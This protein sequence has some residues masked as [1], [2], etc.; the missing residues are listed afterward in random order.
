V[1]L[2]IQARTGFAHE[3][4]H[5]S[6]GAARVAD[7]PI[8]RCAVL[9]AEACNIGLE[10]VVRSAI[11]ALTRSR[12]SWVQ[13]NDLRADTLVRANACLVDP[14]TTIPWAQEWGGGAGASAEGLRVVVPVRTS[15]AGP[16]RQ[17]GNAE[18]GVPY[19][20]FTSDH[21]TGFHALVIPGTLRAS[22]CIVDGLLAHQ[23]RLRPLAIMTDTA[24][25][26]A[27]V[28]GLFWL[29]GD[30]VSPRLA[31][32]GEAQCWRVDRR[33]DDGVL[34]GLARSRVHTTRM[35]RNWDDL[36]RVAGSLHQGTV[37]AS[38]LLRALRRSQ[39]PSTLPRASGA[40]GRIA[41]TRSLVASG[42]EAR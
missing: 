22:M 39:R 17:Y 14:Q 20:P 26:S 18:R 21:C 25:V 16:N 31:D 24:G 19:D 37:S 2:E 9:L 23:T 7:L 40:L 3:L 36:W 1:L 11:P 32:I 4:P 6:E 13:H 30:Q 28:L 38:D 34:N 12:R 29:R 10:P 35:A 27:V 8:R 41:K 5:S 15:T 33:A 42:D